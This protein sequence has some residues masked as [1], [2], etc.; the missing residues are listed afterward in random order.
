MPKAENEKA[1]RSTTRLVVSH[2]ARCPHFAGVSSCCPETEVFEQFSY[3]KG[4]A[5]SV[6]SERTLVEV[7]L[8]GREAARVSGLSKQSCECAVSFADEAAGSKD[9]GL[10]ESWMRQLETK[11][12]ARKYCPH[13]GTYPRFFLF[14]P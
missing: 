7:W 3:G 2:S 9:R 6:F 5:T 4:T 1:A 13:T 12:R 11:L 14:A 8:N 10:L